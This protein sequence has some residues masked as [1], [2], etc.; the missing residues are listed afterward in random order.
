MTRSTQI[1]VDASDMPS[2]LMTPV[3][4]A[5]SAT[6]ASATLMNSRPSRA[7]I[8]LLSSHAWKSIDCA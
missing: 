8:A 3:T 1:G 5:G 6:S 2:G 4:S 7:M